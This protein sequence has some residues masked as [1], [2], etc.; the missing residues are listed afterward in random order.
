MVQLGY[1]GFYCMGI[2][3]FTVNE[4]MK[5]VGLFRF[6]H[7]VNG[8]QNFLLFYWM[9]SAWYSGYVTS[10]KVVS[11]FYCTAYEGRRF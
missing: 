1:K 3:S 6:I 4:K 5:N 9:T 11:G 8:C 2:W 10:G 7:K